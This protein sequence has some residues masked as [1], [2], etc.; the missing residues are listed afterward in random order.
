[1]I[2]FDGFL[3]E[4]RGHAPYPW[5]R[6]LAERLA[7]ERVS[8]TDANAGLPGSVP[9]G[10]PP[11]LTIAVP[12]GSGKTTVVDV[13]VWALAKQADRPPLERTVGARIVWAIDR[14]LLVDEVH[15]QTKRLTD[16]LA[17]A[18]RRPSD[19][20]HEVA[21]R[22]ESLKGTP[23]VG[24]W[25]ATTGASA[26]APTVAGDHADAQGSGLPDAEEPDTVADPALVPEGT[27]LRGRPLVATRWRGGV[28][29]PSIGQ[30]PMQAEV[31]TSTVAQIGSRLLFRGYG[32]GDRSLPL[33]AALA[34]CDTTICLDEAHLAEPFA[35][36]VQAIRERRD[37]G[38]D[39]F[40]PPLRLIRLSATSGADDAQRITLSKEDKQL[41]ALATR[42]EAPKHAT[43]VEPSGPSDNDQ[44]V[45]LVEAV[46]GYVDDGRRTVACVVNSVRTAR[47]VY[48]RVERTY[49]KVEEEHRPEAV[50]LIGPQRPA[51]RQN[52]LGRTIAA[53][54]D[55]GTAATPAA[56][57]SD[58]SPVEGEQSS[59]AAVPT[60]TP[61]R[62]LLDGI[63]A[64]RPL[65]VVATQTFEVG[66]D[67][68]VEALVT[69]SA[70]ATALTQRLGRL[71]RTG[72]LNPRDHAD[73]KSRAT[74]PEGLATIVR[75]VDFPLYA[76]DEDAAW[77]WLSTTLP[78][79]ESGA[80]DVSVATLSLTPAPPDAKRAHAAELGD[81]EVELLTQTSP[82]P[83]RRIDPDVDAFLRGAE[84]EPDS[85]VS[86]CWRADLAEDDLRDGA[87]A[88]RL[89]LL[90]LVPP[91]R[92]EQ[93][94]MSIGAVRN[95]L[96]VRTG[97]SRA[98]KA[99]QSQLIEETADVEGSAPPREAPR[100]ET[101]QRF[102]GIP[103]LVRRGRELLPGR[104]V[105]GG[106]LGDGLA[107]GDLR[108]GDLL[109]LPTALGGVDDSGLAI[110]SP[111][112]T[113]VAGDVRPLGRETDG[114][115][116][117]SDPQSGPSVAVRPHP[118]RLT[119]GALDAAYHEA[120]P[121]AGPRAQRVRRVLRRVAEIERRLENVKSPAGRLAAF[122]DL[123]S[124]LHDHPAL[125]P[126][127]PGEQAA[128]DAIATA[129]V[130]GLAPTDVELR[131]ITPTLPSELTDPVDDPAGL[132]LGVPT[133]SDDA[134]LF[135]G[136]VEDEDLAGDDG[137]FAG[138]LL[139]EDDAD[140]HGGSAD[141]VLLPGEDPPMATGG[142]V[143]LPTM[144][145]AHDRV[146]PRNEPP[147]TL[148][149]HAQAV[150]DRT[151][152]F[153]RAAGL[154]DV[155]VRSLVLAA[156]VHDHGKADPRM[157][158]FFRSGFAPPLAEP[159]AKSVFGTDDRRADRTARLASGLP[160]GWRHEQASTVI[161]ADAWKR[162]QITGLPDDAERGV[163]L[164]L[165]MNLVAAHHG[166]AH[167]VPPVPKPGA[168][169]RSFRIEA[170]GI[171]GTATGSDDEAWSEGQAVQRLE[172]LT[173]DYG[174]WSLAYLQSL[175][176]LADRTVSAEGR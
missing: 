82:R 66:L 30:H 124:E 80:I 35:D 162:G 121:L 39:T 96:A 135:L 79:T 72:R 3:R 65:V 6:A 75:H 29:V 20:L 172:R 141:G 158:A 156:R 47:E 123:F 88:Y 26:S 134:A 113:D 9:V 48:E 174:T 122:R 86:V 100:T 40:A 24:G 137:T 160:S 61:R 117:A 99:A 63:A 7:A 114:G 2:D 5:Q 120:I 94:T 155:L 91:R 57:R 60:T 10:G 128:D 145:T 93:L 59:E 22:L 54:G 105:S 111:V 103:F 127:T 168:P 163:D 13:L 1:M 45:A 161:L 77:T 38:G 167:P 146:R 44:V 27:V 42:L 107:I 170:A 139:S 43:L 25:A 131:R 125:A 46:T 166:A 89:S 133:V 132:F 52:S 153:A 32:L 119:T 17:L 140:G 118:L 150:A 92:D 149:A 157:Q 116:P 51:D 8:D 58:A 53:D 106:D 144:A 126:V 102:D 34:A 64:V 12:T 148:E 136:D 73:G 164:E 85:D 69:Q 95:L 129:T 67:A 41:E 159:I 76:D 115:T 56:D 4:V 37:D 171:A 11:P 101:Q 147:P 138:D 104:P 14:R 90:R 71:N 18:L 15:A 19:P 154:S 110:E 62:V 81:Q 74:H 176:V 83:H 21:V 36:T 55:D 98:T 112:G 109:V 97:Q 31:I 151:A 152:W 108:P 49:G 68:D 169:P 23:P 175:L 142:W 70:S 33:G 165:T 78:R 173:S 84:S 50:L 28:A 16:R 143:L 87:H 130:S